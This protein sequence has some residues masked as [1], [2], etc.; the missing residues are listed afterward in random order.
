MEYWALQYAKAVEIVS[1]EFLREK[2]LN[3]LRNAY[4]KY[5]NK[6]SESN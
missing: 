4:E 2:V 5:N 6:K 1:P 3:S